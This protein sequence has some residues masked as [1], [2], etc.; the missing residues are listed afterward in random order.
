M[1]A[2][3]APPEDPV[4]GRLTESRL[5]RPSDGPDGPLAQ[6]GAKPAPPVCGRKWLR[7]F[8][9]ETARLSNGLATD[10]QWYA[11]D[12]TACL[13]KGFC[14]RDVIEE[15]LAAEGC[16]SVGAHCGDSTS[17]FAMATLWLNVIHDSVCGCYHEVVLSIDANLTRTDAS[18]FRASP[19]RAPWAVQYPSF[20]S[21]VCDAQFLHSLWIN[22]PLS[23]AWGREMQAFPKHP[24]PVASTITD[25]PQQFA[26]DLRWD[27]RVVMR[28]QVR[29]RFGLSGFTRESLGL[30]AAH[31]PLR[32]TRFLAA[33][34][35]EV[36]LLMPAKTA[37]QHG[38]SR[39]YR[40]H[41]WKGLNPAAVRVWPWGADDVLELGDFAVPTEC[42]DHNGQVL[43]RKAEFKPVAVTYV[44]HASAFIEKH[45]TRT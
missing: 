26:F 13:I 33:K 8:R 7:S 34:S 42:E 12:F 37:A 14:R 31:G 36:P 40:A 9:T 18:A 15:A 32:V 28:G 30:V 2:T 4:L 39:Y 16:H 3:P 23:I 20:G 44:P 24:K 27:D 10:R 43:L 22:S 35:F 17:P 25:D 45:P 1:N 29:K 5:G 6:W 41:L 38:L 19:R 11:F 21:S